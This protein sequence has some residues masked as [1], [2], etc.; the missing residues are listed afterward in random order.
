MFGDY[1]PEFSSECREKS[2]QRWSFSL[3]WREA[4]PLVVGCLEYGCWKGHEAYQVEG[5]CPL[6]QTLHSRKTKHR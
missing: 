2:T 1:M 5:C 4:E 6:L 3:K